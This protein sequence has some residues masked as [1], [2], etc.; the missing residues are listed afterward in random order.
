MHC[1]DVIT[2]FKR[3]K[4]PKH[5]LFIGD[6]N[7]TRDYVI[8]V[9]KESVKDPK[10]KTPAFTFSADEM[11]FDQ[12]IRD[13]LLKKTDGV[14]VL[15]E[16]LRYLFKGYFPDE[17]IFVVPN[18][19]DI[20]IKKQKKGDAEKLELLYLSNLQPSKGIED[21][22]KAMTFLQKEKVHLTIVGQWR[23]KETQNYCQTNQYP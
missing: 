3:S 8:D 13:A 10:E 12:E 11:D 22:I 18:G 17:R 9:I 6:K 1:I 7:E 14:I 19:L 20:T 15:G 16:K 21:V 23:D 5:I 4:P 2:M